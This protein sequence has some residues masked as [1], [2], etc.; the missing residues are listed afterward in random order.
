LVLR[1]AIGCL[2]DAGTLAGQ[3]ASDLLQSAIFAQETA[4]DLDGA[5][6][7]YRQILSSPPG[8]RAYAAQAQYRLGICLLRKGDTAGGVEALQ[9]VIR[10]F[11]EE[12]EFV[13]LARESMPNPGGLLP[14]PWSESEVAEYRWAIPNVDD[15]WSLTRIAPS[16]DRK[17]LRIQIN[18][19]S[20]RLYRTT[21]EVDRAR[22]RPVRSVYRAP[23]Q[24]V[25]PGLWRGVRMAETGPGRERTAVYEYGEVLYLLRRMPLYTGWAATIPVSGPDGILTQLNA[26][27]T[28]V[29]TITAPAGKFKCFRVSL[30]TA[31]GTA[32][33]KYS[34]AGTDWQTADQLLWYAVDGARPL[35]KMQVGPSV[36]E[37]TS[38]RTGESQGA[39]SYRD[40]AVGFSFAVPAGW[41]YHSRPGS[42]GEGT[43]VDLLDP[44]LEV[45]VT[46]AFKA[47]KTASAEIEKELMAGALTEQGLRPQL[48]TKGELQKGQIGGRASVT[49]IGERDGPEGRVVRMTTWVQSESTRGSIA[50]TVPATEFDRFRARFQP[51]LDSFRMP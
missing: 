29:E 47:K 7:I 3:P 18:F 51:I 39:T 20:P 6:R 17:N 34:A 36:G 8:M 12:R 49:W 43:S 23:S 46:I 2:W 4:G 48:A 24:P 40:P 11:P 10:N 28:G 30:A 42:T 33:S 25:R 26:S 38:V 13:A 5:I 21:V 44:D 15:G 32:A 22:L 37:L 31:P 19:Y 50:V 41:V 9:A 16:P 45:L 35:V 1:I 27:V 14:A